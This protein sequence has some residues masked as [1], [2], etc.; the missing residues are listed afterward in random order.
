MVPYYLA[1]EAFGSGH[2]PSFAQQEIHSLPV[3][4][5]RSIEIG[6]AAFH[7]YICLVASP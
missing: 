2:V 5:D 1:E 3:F 7:L 6:P 4:V